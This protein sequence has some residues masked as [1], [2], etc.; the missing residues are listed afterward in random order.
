MIKKTKFKLK[1]LRQK[2]RGAGVLIK[3]DDLI[4]NLIQLKCL[5]DSNVLL[6]YVFI[7]RKNETM[8]PS[9]EMIKK[10][11]DL[12]I[13]RPSFKLL[14]ALITT[15]C[16]LAIKSNEDGDEDDEFDYNQDYVNDTLTIYK[17]MINKLKYT[18]NVYLFNSVLSM[19]LKT[20][21][22]IKFWMFFIKNKDEINGCFDAFTYGTL[23]EMCLYEENYVK[24]KKVHD[25]YLKR[26][27]RP[28]SSTRY[29]KELY[30][31]MLHE[32]NQQDVEYPRREWSGLFIKPI[33]GIEW[34]ETSKQQTVN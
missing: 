26:R 25:N 19:L 23:M 5:C 16:K 21:K 24:F 12:N 20:K 4:D 29:V 31:I 13:H 32:K 22:K 11:N 18:P 30:K 34:D 10:M 27:F 9:E 6:Q 15:Y 1:K 2:K 7:N 33:D 14:A 8:P 3:A 28:N 17:Y